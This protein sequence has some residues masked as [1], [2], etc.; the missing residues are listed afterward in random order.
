M[1]V[2]TELV[3][4]SALKPYENN[5]RRNDDAVKP[6]AESIKA[7]GFKVPIVI[8]SDNVIVA[9]HTRY[10]AAQ[11]IGLKQV[12]C[13]RASHLSPKQIKAFRL[14]DNKV[15]EKSVWDKALL[16]AEVGSLLDAMDLSIFGF[17]IKQP[18][19][20]DGESTPGTGVAENDNYI[21][22]P[23]CKARLLKS[24]VANHGE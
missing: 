11:L 22:C 20:D 7:F 24:E 1:R 23:R 21:I 14:A 3:E 5:P 12:P 18:K 15:G 16:N 17:E 19:H 9:G 13:I 2:Q 6:V 4:L 10:K 8:D